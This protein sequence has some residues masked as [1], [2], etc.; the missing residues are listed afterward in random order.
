M[1]WRYERPLIFPIP[2]HM[3]VN[4]DVFNLDET[5]TI[6]IP[7]NATGKDISLANFLVRELSDKYGMALKIETLSEIPKTGKV[8][9]M[10]TSDNLLVKKYCREN[11]V[12]LSAKNPGAEGYIL[13]V[14]TSH[15]FYWGIG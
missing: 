14:N 8:V 12:Q 11:N 15:Y 4:K 7:P 9:V 3:E 2:Q 5:V 6:V 13:Q 1:L 10:G